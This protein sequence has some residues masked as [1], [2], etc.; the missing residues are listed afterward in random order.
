MG[1]Q[2]VGVPGADNEVVQEGCW[3]SLL[4]LKTEFYHSRPE[5]T[6]SG[7]NS[8][9]RVSRLVPQHCSYLSGLTDTPRP[10]P[11]QPAVLLALAWKPVYC[12]TVTGTSA[13][14]GA[15]REPATLS[16]PLSFSKAS[17]LLRYCPISRGRRA[18]SCFS[19]SPGTPGGIPS[20]QEEERS[21]G[22]RGWPTSDGIVACLP[23]A[24]LANL[25]YYARS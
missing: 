4:S 20:L 15:I 17:G 21:T 1:R 7:G 18:I 25:P 12:C 8:C 11:P 10:R 16:P 19:N 24:I 13:Q 14:R 22:L 2:L 5:I 6:A 23:C 9:P 3:G